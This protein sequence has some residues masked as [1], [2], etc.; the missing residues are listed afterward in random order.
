MMLTSTPPRLVPAP[1]KLWEIRQSILALRAGRVIPS[2]VIESILGSITWF[3]LPLR[4][5]LTTPIGMGSAASPRRV[6]TQG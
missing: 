4:S 6:W 2:E 3:F 1:E 5:S